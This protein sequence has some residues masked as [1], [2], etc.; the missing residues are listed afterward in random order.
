M[1]CAHP[2]DRKVPARLN[3]LEDELSGEDKDA[4]EIGEDLQ[5]LRPTPPCPSS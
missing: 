1:R 5:R 2:D 3:A 4:H